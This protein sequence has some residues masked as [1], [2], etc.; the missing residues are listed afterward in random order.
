MD[1]DGDHGRGLA[2]EVG[3]VTLLISSFTLLRIETEESGLG[4]AL[5]SHFKQLAGSWAQF[6]RANRWLVSWCHPRKET[7]EDSKL[8]TLTEGGWYSTSVE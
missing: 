2:C 7:V 5:C 3:V 4:V 8:I 6:T 1:I